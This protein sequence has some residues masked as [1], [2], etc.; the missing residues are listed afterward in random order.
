M[1]PSPSQKQTIEPLE[2]RISPND[3]NNSVFAKKKSP[4]SADGLLQTQQNSP[5]GMTTSEIDG[6]RSGV[7]KL[8]SSF[9]TQHS[10]NTGVNG[11]EQTVLVPRLQ[12]RMAKSPADET[13]SG[14]DL[15]L[16][17]SSHYCSVFWHV[18][19]ERAQIYEIKSI[20]YCIIHV[21]ENSN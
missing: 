2:I 7:S 14:T 6:R 9:Q 11:L 19:L 21:R 13:V 5:G 17:S 18:E 10:D 20:L 1:N 8:I 4:S 15:F 16:S 12:Q 3:T